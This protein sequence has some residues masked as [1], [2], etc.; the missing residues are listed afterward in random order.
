MG[1]NGNALKEFDLD[2][3]DDR[4]AIEA[5]KQFIDGHDIELWQGDRKII[6]FEHKD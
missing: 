3:P 6:E 4:A 2:R 5:A 1:T